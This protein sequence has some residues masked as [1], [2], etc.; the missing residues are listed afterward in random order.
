MMALKSTPHYSCIMDRGRGLIS[1]KLCMHILLKHIF[2][3]V[4]PCLKADFHSLR[5]VSNKAKRWWQGKQNRVDTFPNLPF[6]IRD[7]PSVIFFGNRCLSHQENTAQERAVDSLPTLHQPP[8]LQVDIYYKFHRFVG[9]ASFP[10]GIT[11]TVLSHG[12]WSCCSICFYTYFPSGYILL[13]FPVLPSG[14]NK[15]F[16]DHIT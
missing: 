16:I 14:A 3:A 13:E 15:I 1:G 6:H 12:S 11:L 2:H 7:I 4:T 9:W 5:T 8:A 10:K